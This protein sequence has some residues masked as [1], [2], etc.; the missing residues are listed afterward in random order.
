MNV[1]P[2]KYGVF[3]DTDIR[4]HYWEYHSLAELN[5]EWEDYEED[6]LLYVVSAEHR[7]GYQCVLKE[8]YP[9]ICKVAKE[10][11]VGFETEKECQKTVEKLKAWKRL[12]EAGAEF[13]GW[14]RNQT[15][16]YELY[17]RWYDRIPRSYEVKK[18]LD[19]LFGGE[20]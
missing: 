14:R 19:L 15:G 1:S 11:G 3:E 6:E 16:T 7:S 8:D 17:M 13:Y 2:A 12:K 18:D 10:L 20:E 4:G 5:E 9:E